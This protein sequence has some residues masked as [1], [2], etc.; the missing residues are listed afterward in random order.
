[1]KLKPNPMDSNPPIV[2]II[3]S[4]I[5]QRQ[6]KQAQFKSTYQSGQVVP[7]ILDVHLIMFTFEVDDQIT[8]TVNVGNPHR[9]V[10]GQDP[11]PSSAIVQTRSG[12]LSCLRYF[13]GVPESVTGRQAIGGF[14]TKLFPV[15]IYNSDR[16]QIEYI[17][18]LLINYCVK[19]R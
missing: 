5:N 16:I 14:F 15:I 9:S 4:I 18:L 12:E 19:I 2:A 11:L 3:K 6:F 7:K 13:S 10:Q 17:L 8:E 1:M